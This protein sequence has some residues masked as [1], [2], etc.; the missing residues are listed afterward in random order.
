VLARLALADGDAAAAVA[1]C[2]EELLL[3]DVLSGRTDL[4]LL[5]ETWGW[6]V[7]VMRRVTDEQGELLHRVRAA[8]AERRDR[9]ERVS[10]TRRELA[11][12][13]L[14]F[15]QRMIGHPM[16]GP[17]ALT[18]ARRLVGVVG[19]PEIVVRTVNRSAPMWHEA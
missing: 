3:A 8:V 19:A 15:C 4:L 1:L 17:F 2:H 10:L 5:A 18:A 16:L 12:I 7:A 11:E 14:Q 13:G 9:P 6:S